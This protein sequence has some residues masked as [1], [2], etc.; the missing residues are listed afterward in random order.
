MMY[1]ILGS[2]ALLSTAGDIRML[3]RG[4]IS[5]TPRLVRHLWRMC[6][7]LFIASASL[8]LSRP[9]LFPA[10]LNKTYVITLLGFLPL[11]MM[12]FWLF[13]VRYKPPASK[14]EAGASL[15]QSAAVP[16][17]L[18]SRASAHR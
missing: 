16:P 5:G 12:I 1:F 6:F 9:R 11:I 8:F 15:H 14:I 17:G 18:A 13:R 4:G 2:I 3:M 7:G 10:I